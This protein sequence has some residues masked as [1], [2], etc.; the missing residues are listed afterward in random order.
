[1]K[2]L[3]KRSEKF[4]FLHPKSSFNRSQE[5]TRMF[6]AKLFVFVET[7]V[8]DAAVEQSQ[9]FVLQNFCMGEYISKLL[10]TILF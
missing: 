4:S 6:L 5:K 2:V 8:H 7:T 9:E 1:M 3:L 10:L